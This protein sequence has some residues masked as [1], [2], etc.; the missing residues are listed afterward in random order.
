MFECGEGGRSRSE[1]CNSLF[2]EQFCRF[3]LRHDANVPACL[4]VNG[5]RFFLAEIV[6]VLSAP[7]LIFACERL[8]GF[9]AD[10]AAMPEFSNKIHPLFTPVPTD[11]A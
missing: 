1:L 3:G 8:L 6:A 5:M 2:H 4:G 11:R 7:T 9:L 10:A